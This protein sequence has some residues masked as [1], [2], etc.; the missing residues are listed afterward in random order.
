MIRVTRRRA[1][2]PHRC[3]CGTTIEPGAVYL[4]HVASP[5]HQDLENSRWWR[6][7][8]CAGCATRYGRAELLEASGTDHES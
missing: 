8:E 4:E 5:H 1:R 7:A 3:A 6:L 2:R